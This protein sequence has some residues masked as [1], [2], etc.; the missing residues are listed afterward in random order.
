LPTVNP[1]SRPVCP[2]YLSVT[3]GEEGFPKDAETA[4]KA[5]FLTGFGCVHARCA[6]IE[7]SGVVVDLFGDGF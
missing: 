1:R 2:T 4:G 6:E 7:G 3:Y 5:R